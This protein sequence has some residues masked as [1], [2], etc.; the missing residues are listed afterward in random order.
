MYRLLRTATNLGM[1]VS[2]LVE[3]EEEEEGQEEEA[4]AE[5]KV[6]DGSMSEILVDSM[7]AKTKRH[8]RKEDPTHATLRG[9]R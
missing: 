7:Q 2:F 4:V 6:G 9:S 8:P 3:G 5:G 1:V